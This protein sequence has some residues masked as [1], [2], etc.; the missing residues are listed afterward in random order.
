MSDDVTPPLPKRIMHYPKAGG[1]FQPTLTGRFV[2]P[3]S[4]KIDEMDWTG[5]ISEFKEDSRS[6]EIAYDL[7][8]ERSDLDLLKP[9]KEW[10]LI[11]LLD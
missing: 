6:H 11:G 5:V 8:G 2:A 3:I 10:K 1:L 7:D 9:Q 4:K